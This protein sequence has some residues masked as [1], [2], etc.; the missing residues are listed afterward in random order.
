MSIALEPFAT[1]RTVAL[2]T[3][4]RDGTPV[5]TP[6]SIAV[7]GDR[8]VFRSF[9]E[10][11]KTRRLRRDP[12]VEVAPST[13]RGR[14]TGPA[15]RATA[16]LLD[17]DEADDAA[18]LLRRK[19]PFLHGILVPLAHRVGRRRTGRTVHFELVPTA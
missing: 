7:D 18:R 2:T 15:I 14:P 11:G 1:Q 12:T 10:A 9:A 5:S 17:G 3:F 4:R 6:V 16:R 19:H 8:A 13:F